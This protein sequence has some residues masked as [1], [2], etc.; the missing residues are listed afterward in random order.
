MEII[1]PYEKTFKN[2]EYKAIDKIEQLLDKDK[3][4][5][6]KILSIVAPEFLCEQLDF[7]NLSS[8]AIF[9]INRNFQEKYSNYDREE[10]KAAKPSLQKKDAD[11]KKPLPL[12]A[13]TNIVTLCDY[14]IER[15]TIENKNLFI[16]SCV[17]KVT[18]RLDLINLDQL[19][20]FQEM[21]E[22]SYN[23]DSEG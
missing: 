18:N 13:K 23:F 20:I 16:L 4:I 12:P 5:F 6:I 22:H 9:K 8:K 15:E 21:Q 19:I 3:E 7:N 14:F 17:A 2:R 10:E 1:D 11:K